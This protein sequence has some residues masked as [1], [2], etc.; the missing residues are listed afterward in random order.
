[1][2]WIVIVSIVVVSAIKIAITCLPTPVVNKLLQKFEIHPKLDSKNT[3][4]MINNKVLEDSEKNQTIKYF[5]ES[6]FLKQYYIHP[7]N[8]RYFLEPED[9]NEPHVIKTKLG[10]NDVEFRVFRYKD[11][12]DIVK[13]YKKKVK[14]YTVLSDDFKGEFS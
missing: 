1:M 5:N 13:Q 4:V 9:A 6:T 11:R 2:T 12:V 7:G 3:T 8:E 14:A 10:K